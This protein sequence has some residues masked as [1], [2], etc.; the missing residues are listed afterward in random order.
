[1]TN[2]ES[3]IA[4]HHEVEEKFT[5]EATVNPDGSFTDEL[6]VKQFGE[7]DVRAILEESGETLAVSNIDYLT[8]EPPWYYKYIQWLPEWFRNLFD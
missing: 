8:I 1:M 3:K 7:W 2:N 4:E 5:Q 6:T